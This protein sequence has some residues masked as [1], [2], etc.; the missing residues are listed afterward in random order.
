MLEL[1]NQV[2]VDRVIRDTFEL[3]STPSITGNT[4][5]VASKIH[6]L[7]EEV[8]FE[9]TRHDFVPDNPTLFAS[10]GDESKGKTLLF[11]G[12]MDVIPVPNEAPQILADKVI[13]R[14]T[15]DMKGSFACLVEAIRVMKET[16]TTPKGRILVVANS[17]HESPLGHGEDLYIM[18]EKLKEEK[19]DAAV[20][21]ESGAFDCTIATFGS[22]N[23]VITVSRDG[24]PS[25]QLYTRPGTPHPISVAAEVVQELDKLN[26]VI[27]QEYVEDIGYE[28][29]F[30]GRITSGQFFNQLPKH[31][32]IEGVRR[33][34]P[35][36]SYDHVKQEMEA[37]LASIAKKHGVEIHL[38]LEKVRDGYRTPK[39]DPIVKSLVKAV[40]DVRHIEFPLVGRQ[41]VTDAGIF[42]NNIGVPTVCYGPDAQSAHSETEH[43][44][45]SELDYTTK[46]YLGLIN[47]FLGIEN[48]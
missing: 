32:E 24:E 13:G 35:T 29:Y 17:L 3:V 40:Q 23:F 27:G 6:K 37:L 25:H 22:A 28:S 43:V 26:K 46:I 9:V 15:C 30:I 11:S 21:M 41:L 38:R 42:A 45:I 7:L 48:A 33:Y 5:E 10:F 34:S 39:Q 16:G 47:D 4:T 19:I 14:G 12:H 31:A 2:Q 18:A 8:G 36:S 20:V 44:K 1:Q